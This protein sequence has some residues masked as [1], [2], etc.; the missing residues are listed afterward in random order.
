MMATTP[1]FVE[2]IVIGVGAFTALGL[3]VTATI[4]APWLLIRDTT[5]IIFA[6]PFLALSYVLGIIVDRLADSLHNTFSRQ[7][8]KCKPFAS[9]MEYHAA[10]KL[11]R[12]HSGPAWQH[13]EYTRS[14]IRICRGW[15]LNCVLLLLGANLWIWLQG[16][17]LAW[18]L[19]SSAVVSAILLLIFLGCLF[20]FWSLGQSYHNQVFETHQLLLTLVP[21]SGVTVSQAATVVAVRPLEPRRGETP[22]LVA[23]SV[24]GQ[25]N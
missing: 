6:F 12:Y 17:T 16:N 13:L 23:E 7:Q 8:W 4:D 3:I 10:H 21:L 22:E 24:R 9:M 5:A 1:L 20:S 11:I 19:T 15:S 14:R 25:A 2:I 18:S